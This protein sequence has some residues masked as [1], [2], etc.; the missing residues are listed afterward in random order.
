LLN[1]A[2][3]QR[4]IDVFHEHSGMM[5]GALG[6]MEAALDRKAGFAA[7]R[8]VE[9]DRT[10]V[11]RIEDQIKPPSAIGFDPPPPG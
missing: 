2:G 4:K 6:S 9:H 8:L 7:E 1:K 3:S 11:K 5:P 10:T